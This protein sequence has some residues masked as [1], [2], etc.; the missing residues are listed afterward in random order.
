MSFHKNSGGIEGEDKVVSVYRTLYV[1]TLYPAESGEG[2][3]WKTYRPRKSQG[4]QIKVKGENSLPC[5]IAN[6]S[7]DFKDKALLFQP[8][9]LM[10]VK[11]KVI[12]ET[13]LQP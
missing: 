11:T 10:F 13:V 9:W 5:P 3:K 2:K 8:Q 6:D 4:K 7:H 1:I 12:V